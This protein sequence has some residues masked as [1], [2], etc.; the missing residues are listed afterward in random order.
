MDTNKKDF[1]QD[2]MLLAL[3]ELEGMLDRMPGTPW[4][5]FLPTC[6]DVIEGKFLNPPISI[7][8]AK[9]EITK[10]RMDVFKT[11]FDGFD[12]DDK[13]MTGFVQE[14]PV[15]IRFVHTDYDFMKNPEMVFYQN[16][17]YRV[18]NPISEYLKV[19]KLVK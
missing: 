9:R 10:E 15:V 1:T 5:F 2:E 17:Y 18:P 8:I 7:G 14:V 6:N 3:R 12:I 13:G 16:E 11:Y 4:M 19:W